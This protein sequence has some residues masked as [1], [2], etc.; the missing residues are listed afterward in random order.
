[1]QA[2]IERRLTDLAACDDT[3]LVDLARHGDETAART[4]VQR[5][6][7]RLFRTARAIL[8]DDS[9]A[10]DAVQEA[11]MRAFTSLSG[12]RGEASLSTWL[13]RIVLNEALGRIRR[14]RPSGSADDIDR[15]MTRTEGSV[16][17]FPTTQASADPETN[18]AREQIR[19]VVEQVV[20]ELPEP[21]RVVFILR[22]VEDMST[23]E[24]AAHLSIKQET[25]K[26]RLH[27]AR[28]LIRAT[29][30]ERFAAAFPEL[31]P[32][33][34]RRCTNMADRIVQRLRTEGLL[35]SV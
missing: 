19:R 24:V 30:K 26:T 23:E 25:V 18:L 4:I 28:R 12:F 31:F 27:R 14:R 16:I 22:D 15:L 5:H 32:F 34:G 35:P 8:R 10:E 6:N 2:A 1:M 20:D 21:F 9:E 33:D 11:Y 29:L 3:V 17:M 7:R 13:T